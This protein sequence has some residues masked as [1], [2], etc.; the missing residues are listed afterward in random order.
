MLSNHN[1]QKLEINKRSKFGK[2]TNM[3]LWNNVFLA[4]TWL[5]K[6]IK[7]KLENTLK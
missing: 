3:W 6:E 4:K 1:R 7:G 5:K 2:L